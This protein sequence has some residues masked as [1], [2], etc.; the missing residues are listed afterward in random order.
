MKWIGAL[1]VLLLV[2][3]GLLTMRVLT[4][5]D[6]AA[7][8]RN[9]A[10]Q[11]TPEPLGLRAAYQTLRSEGHRVALQPPGSDRPPDPQ[12]AWWIMQAGPQWFESADGKV[13]V[14]LRF[15]QRGGTVVLIPEEAVIPIP[16]EEGAQPDAPLDAFFARLG[17]DVRIVA[18]E[19]QSP[20]EGE[21][22]DDDGAAEVEA[23][24]DG[25]YTLAVSGDEA[26]FTHVATVET[27]WGN[28]F[29][30]ES[31][32]KANIRLHS[33]GF[34]LVAEFH[35]GKGTLVLVAES[36]YFENEFI[37]RA[38]NKS[39]LLALATQYSRGG[40]QFHPTR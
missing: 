13:P 18:F 15:I 9:D 8:A 28:Y 22:D 24:H 7:F 11:L 39:L 27:S 19:P 5:R 16:G 12:F 6:D 2:V 10:E 17:L 3:A 31:L 34:P 14:M 36:T 20:D 40:I 4:L 33:D 30:G 1:S 26:P 32:L 23:P 38:E 37:D 35:I 25:A 29:D 21:E